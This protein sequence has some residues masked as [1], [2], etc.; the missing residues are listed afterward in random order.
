MIG[1]IGGTGLEKSNFLKNTETINLKTKFGNP[2]SKII[3]GDIE[4]KKIAI[5]SRHGT[6][7]TI[8]PTHVNNRANISALKEIGCNCI[9]ATSACGSLR[10]DIKPGDFVIPDQFIDFTKHR[11]NTFYDSFEPGLMQ[12][13]PMADPFSAELRK[14]IET[15]SKQSTVKLHTKGTIL[16]IEGPRFSTRSE[17]HMFRLWGADIINMSTAPETAL[18]NEANIPY[19]VIAISTDYDCWKTDEE[20]V[21]IDIV[22]KNF[23]KSVS[24]LVELL[25]YTVKL[26]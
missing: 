2:S 4:N 22:L 10:E 13:C 15:A 26:I 8:T 25:V 5:I 19:A 14:I 17:S 16:T 3:T 9:I 11:I 18:A 12:H 1:I 7:H 23:A 20:P 21:S 6:E 24:K